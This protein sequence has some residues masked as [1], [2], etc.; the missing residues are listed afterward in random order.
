MLLSQTSVRSIHLTILFLFISFAGFSQT[1]FVD[2]STGNN[3][4]DGSTPALAKLTI[5]AA[6]DLATGGETISV[7]A[8]TYTET[9]IVNKEV[10]LEGPF[11][12][13]AGSD[14]GRGTGE[15]IIDQGAFGNVV[16][17]DG[18]D[19]V[20]IDGFQVGSTMTLQGIV[21]DGNTNITIQNNVII[22]HGVGLNFSNPSGISSGTISIANNL[23]DMIALRILAT[24]NGSVGIIVTN[25][26]GTSEVSIEDNNLVDASIGIG[27]SGLNSS[28]NTASIQGGSITG[29]TT[30]I[31][32]ANIDDLATSAASDIVISGI[33]MSG[34]AIDGTIGGLVVGVYAFATGTGTTSADDLALDIDNLD[35]SGTTNDSTNNAA[36]IIADF[37]SGEPDTGISDDKGITVTISNTNVHDNDNRGIYVRGADAS[38]TIST[39]SIIDNGGNASGSGAGL[40]TFASGAITVENSTIQNPGVQVSGAVSAL[41]SQ[42]NGSIIATSNSINRN[43]NGELGDIQSG[44]TANMSQNWLGTSIESEIEPY[45][46]FAGVDF[47]P[48]VSSGTDSD[49][50]TDGFQP[51]LDTLYVGASGTQTGSSGRVD[52]AIG[53]VDA[54][55]TIIVN[56]GSYDE[57]VTVI[58][59]VSI[60]GANQG[61]AGN[62]TRI[63][64]TIIDPSAPGVGVTIAANNVTIDGLQLGSSSS[65]SNLSTGIL[66][67][68]SSGTAVTNNVVYSNGFGITVST[69]SANSVVVSNNLVSMLNLVDPQ[70][71]N[72]PSIGMFVSTISGTADVNL[73]DNDIS[74]A[75]YGIGGYALTSENTDYINGG[76][77]TGCTQGIAITNA[78]GTGNF[79]R[80]IAS[81]ENVTM[82][83]FVDPGAGLAAPDAQ[84]G[85]YTGTFTD[86]STTTT[87]DSVEL[88]IIGVDI[89]GTGS[90]PSDYAA[91]NVV[92][93][94]GAFPFIDDDGVAVNVTIIDANLHDNLNRG[95]TIRGTNATATISRSTFTNNSNAAVV[96]SRLGYVD[97]NNNFIINPG[98]GSPTAL[99][100][101]TDGTMAGQHNSIDTGNGTIADGQDADDKINLSG[102]YFGTTDQTTI[103]GLIDA[104]NTDFSPWIASG[105]DTNP[106]FA[107]FQPDLSTLHV[108][109]SGDQATGGIIQEGHDLVDTLGTVVVNGNSYTIDTLDVLKDITLSPLVNLTIDELVTDGGNLTVIDNDLTVT[110]ILT[111]NNGA[112]D[113]DEDEGVKTDDPVLT[114]T[115]ATVSGTFS[116]ANHIEGKVASD[117]GAA[118]SLEFPVGDNGNYR[119]VTITPVS[120][121]TFEVAHYSEAAPD[122]T[123]GTNPS[124]SNLIGDVSTAFS[125]AVIQSALTARYWNI[126]RTS[127]T[128]N[129]DVGLQVLDADMEVEPG[130]LSAVKINSSGDWE[131]IARVG[132][133]GSDP[134]IITGQTSDFSPFSITSAFGMAPGNVDVGLQLWLKADEVTGLNDNDPITSWADMSGLGRDATEVTNPPTY[135]NNV[136]D[137]YNFNPVIITDGMDDILSTTSDPLGDSDDFSI[138]IVG[139]NGS[140]VS[141]GMTGEG[142]GWSIR[143]SGSIFTTSPSEQ[144]DITYP[145]VTPPYIQILTFD[146]GASLN[147]YR[148]GVPATH[149]TGVGTGL[150]SS[151]DFINIGIDDNTPSAGSISELIV[152]NRV[153]DPAEQQRLESY[154][155]IK[156]GIPLLSDYLA[157]DGGTIW[158]T[159]TTSGY[160]F[161]NA[162]IGRD[163]FS[164]LDQRKSRTINADSLVTIALGDF[165]NP[166]AF[167]DN[168]AWLIWGNNNGAITF[169][170][171]INNA[172][173]GSS[174]RIERVWKVQETGVVG[175]VELAFNESASTE[176]ISLIVHPSDETFPNDNDRQVYEMVYSTTTDDYRV[177]V[178]LTNGDYF[179]FAEG[180][181]GGIPVVL[182]SEV[183]TDPQLDWSEDEFHNPNL[184][185]AD[186]GSEDEWVELFITENN[187]DLSDWTIELIDGASANGSLEAG[188]VFTFSNYNSL[189]GG[190][191]QATDSG[192]FVIL[193]D[194]TGVL[195]NDQHVILRNQDG[196]VVDQVII[197]NISRGT[198]FDG[199]ADDAENESVTRLFNDS[200][201]NDDASDF[202]K[203][204]A[205]LG[206]T[207][208]VSGLVLINEIVTDPQTDWSENNFDG[209]DGGNT[210]TPVD[211]WI[212]LYIA[213]DD[214]DLT[215]WV[216]D[217]ENGANDIIQQD[218]SAGG[219]FTISNYFSETGGTFTKTDS[220]DYL[221]LGNAAENLIN[222]PE[223]TL[224]DPSGNIIDQVILGGGGSE[225]PDGNANEFDNE[226]IAR[227]PNAADTDTDNID[228]IQ[229]R[230]T[231]GST[232]SPTGTV[233]I[234]EVVTD[235]FQDW[236]S[237]GFDGII[238]A[239]GS[240]NAGTDEWIE[241]YIT[242][243]SINLTNWSIEL[244]DGTDVIGDLTGTG[245]FG[246]TNYISNTSGSSFSGAATGDYLILGDVNGGSQMSND[247]LITLKDSYGT[248]IDEVQLGGGTG[249]A[250]EGANASIAEES[251]ARIP[252][253]LDTDADDV[254]FAKAEATLGAENFVNPLAS[255]GYGL[256]LDGSDEY[257][258]LGAF[259]ELDGVDEFT[260]EA[261]INVDNFTDYDGIVSSFESTSSAIDLL[262]GGGVDATNQGI[263]FRVANGSNTHA[264]TTS[265]P[266]VVD[267]W[268]HVVAVYNGNGS[269]N[270][271][272]IQ[273]YIDGIQMDLAFNVGSPPTTTATVNEDMAI[274][275]YI[276][277]GHYLNGQV[278]DVRIWS[279][280]RT[281][282]EVLENMF[283]TLDGTETGLI[284]Y[285][286]LDQTTGS[287]APDLAGT[288]TGSLTNMENA[289]WV[290]TDWST[291]V[292]NQA[293]LNP[294]TGSD[295]TEAISNEL[296]INESDFLNDDGDFILTGHENSDFT[297]VTTDLPSPAGGTLVT[298]RYDR[299]WHLTKNDESGTTGGNVTFSFDLG[300]AP[301]SDYTYYLLERSTNSGAFSVVPVVGV[302][303]NGNNVV[304]TLDAANLT[305]GNYYTLGRSDAGVGNALDFDGTDDYVVIT[306]DNSLDF[307]ST[308]TLEAW[309][310]L[311][312]TTGSRAIVS[313]YFS[314]TSSETSYR[315]QVLSGLLKL[316]VNNSVA[317]TVSVVDQTVGSIST[318]S[319]H[320]IAGVADGSGNILLYMDGILVGTST[321]DNTVYVGTRDVLIGK[322]RVE[323][324]ASITDGI[325]D[326][327]R[328]WNEA[329]TQEEIIDNMFESL[330]GTES[331]LVA[332]YRM[333]QGIGDGNSSLPDLGPN[334]YNGT[335]TNFDNLSA[336]TASSNY[337][338]SNRVTFSDLA[339]IVNAATDILTDV[340]GELTITS[341]TS[342]YL[343]NTND[344]VIWGNDGGNLSEVQTDLPSGTLV[345]NRIEK[346][347]NIDKYDASSNNGNLTF[348]FDLGS[349]PDPDY[350]YYLLTRTGTSGDFSVVEVIGS[351]PNGSSVEFTVDG[352]E[353]TD[354]NYFTLGRSEA[355][356]GHALDFDGSNDEVDL[357]SHIASFDIDAPATIEFWY[358]PP[359][360]FDRSIDLVSIFS[361]GDNG[362][363]EL[364]IAYGNTT[365]DLTDEVISIFHLDGTATR[366]AYTNASLD[367]NIHHWTLVASGTEYLIYLDGQLVNTTYADPIAGDFGDNIT[368]TEV[369]IGNRASNG[370]L[371]L[372]GVIDELRIWSDV[373]TSQE[374]QDNLY[375]SLDVANESNLVA[376]YKFNDGLAASD[377]S[378]PA[379][380]ILTDY[381]GN[382]FAGDLSGFALTGS[383]SNWIISEVPLADQSVVSALDGPGN[384][385]AFDGSDEYVSIPDNDA[386]DIT[387]ALTLE[388]W[389]S[390]TSSPSN[391]NEGIVS[392]F[393]SAGDERSYSLDITTSDNL[394][395]TLSANGSNE[396]AL[397][398]TSTITT[399]DG[400]TYVAAVFDPSN[401]MSLYIDGILDTE[402]TSGVPA[403]INASAADLWIGL[404]DAIS[405]NN[406]LNAEIDEVRIWATARTRVEIQD[407]MFKQL[408]GN[409]SGLV[410]YYTFDEITGTN[411]PDESPNNNAGTLQNMETADWVSAAAREPEKNIEVNNW[412]TTATWKSRAVPDAITERLDLGQDIIVDGPV[413]VDLL[414]INSG[415]TVTIETGQTLTVNGNFINNGTITGDGTLVIN[416]GTPILYGGTIS[417]LQLAGAD[418]TLMSATTVGDTLDL[419]S[420]S[421]L[422]IDDYNLMV[423]QISG[424]S[425]SA[426]IETKNQSSPSGYIIK[427][428][429]E[430]DGDFTFPVGS[431]GSYT[432][433][434]VKNLGNTGD[435]EARV[436]DNTYA[437]GTSGPIIT[438]EKE[439]N[440]SWEI[441]G[442]AG[443]NV[444]VTL[445]WNGTDE[446][447]NFS[448]AR[449]TAYMSKND[450]NW[451][452]KITPDVGVTGSDPYMIAASGIHTFSVFGTGTE[453]SSLPVTWMAFE[454]FENEEQ[455]VELHWSTASEL[456]NDRFEIE[457]SFDGSAFQVIGEIIGNGTINSQS[458]YEFMDK[459]PFNGINYYRLRQ[460]D[461]D[462]T[463]DYSELVSVFVD[464]QREYNIVLSPN[465]TFDITTLSIDWESD[466]DYAVGIFDMMGRNLGVVHS[467]F[468][469]LNL[470]LT[471]LPKAMYIIKI[472]TGD[473]IVAKKLIKY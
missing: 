289:D 440:K 226:A 295:I 323:D 285:Y 299:S 415:V 44:G 12:G 281:H 471:T 432:P 459:D 74:N 377:N 330:A 421:T 347:W 17:V 304:F 101:Q 65:S 207:S 66:N 141:R 333:N 11:A 410:A 419:S 262:L 355:G 469:E 430:A 201:T 423:N 8:G 242:S 69:I 434:T 342:D 424:F 249:E 442:D 92:D 457:K 209:T 110:S 216:M 267:T 31:L 404:T 113:L 420:N 441:N 319:W 371:F 19:N 257:I 150:R 231:L 18:V 85:V 99:V 316:Q 149:N 336:A 206:N 266:L 223:I 132:E 256:D 176:T 177:T 391:D 235:P 321:Y 58:K 416:G 49:L 143:S 194:P 313:K 4:D 61:T 388:A 435:I 233:V 189:T 272:R 10:R 185:T 180:P 213:T 125:P 45:M 263:Y 260:I 232:N 217:I 151:T 473:R 413:D 32:I 87:A 197:E 116:D 241:L 62:G 456:N 470:N 126:D 25:A 144:Q 369:K 7:A 36:I 335:L 129:A 111:L 2:A 277:G 118:A 348:A 337:V 302:N 452:E 23:I 338:A 139:D 258:D 379:V 436:F 326:E 95:F 252:N 215:N 14:P 130:T 160:N 383:T 75:S 286:N 376:Y 352:A 237:S 464:I 135:Q 346:T 170:E 394:E 345:T 29:S 458:K 303:P 309:I 230:P 24:A 353:V 114:I 361:L 344:M 97:L 186:V 98:S 3:A 298:A 193:G 325:I 268:H 203:T 175:T 380:D 42:Q 461:Y 305:D 400:W 292:S 406:A 408:E 148:S 146:Q 402:L 250:P 463:D 341:T 83:G 234:N 381:S 145:G 168:D 296:D 159:T 96:V 152:Y 167:A 363:E 451:W 76:T 460:V 122:G 109:T 225:A 389:I 466:D 22:T 64:E 349:A 53:L 334:G 140:L 245:A 138:I 123:G 195:S 368:A 162:G 370:D 358:T 219:A 329:R 351:E 236:S 240:V 251:I 183:I 81:I 339:Y 38:A 70:N 340:S 134:Y 198:G 27:V 154:L 82:A 172:H 100:A 57:T 48:W 399:A 253:G 187:L 445:Q 68:G 288:N 395:F 265:A 164:G 13:T 210:P 447:P 1:I 28:T 373:R 455:Q 178:D 307:T 315:L 350:T 50:G 414:N 467:K 331:G 153:V 156:Y 275:Y 453:D 124:L 56:A 401:S 378:T 54:G 199:N 438:T 6:I 163:D 220:G 169:T 328:F 39:S 318:S 425:S 386:L 314:G 104:T 147:G 264:Y 429:A 90:T 21:S 243:D 468:T 173:T 433:L 26:S 212:E 190:L 73:V 55:G 405:A 366:A 20:T 306:D 409:E 158:N 273:I 63:D 119:P 174:N 431:S 37:N 283:T 60:L 88:T 255:P 443:V 437:Q 287:T 396:A 439:V 94:A 269:T 218:L 270:A 137:N 417:N 357:S 84:A 171:S 356:P 312:N 427:S 228:F 310:N 131:E 182:I 112:I 375:R 202:V 106:S 411:L 16:T 278:D 246:T 184:G 446:D 426:Y 165:D 157:A 105:T 472:H 115:G 322:A 247:V 343:Q 79:N 454:A 280:A 317:S 128:G 208:T 360:G 398:S 284:S 102:N 428:L 450:Y 117:I 248:I 52:E 294:S 155:A 91:I 5:Q 259:T 382:D 46:N 372:E 364:L 422:N 136:T 221:V 367:N 229:T 179:T 200:D 448:S 462:G 276:D 465:P 412:N 89:S 407:N 374:I 40:I 59:A 274:G 67:A 222:S 362:T 261:W 196:N 239:G 188:D 71:A 384:A 385:L 77:I 41:L 205:T 293:I 107:G 192:D 279:T 120:A 86:G 78:D 308:F 300:A 254:D 393:L 392:K 211:E 127:G 418:A 227:Y 244:I 47:T 133:S 365:V 282:E 324:V 290:S 93:F 359:S 33:T 397:T 43:G 34:F 191:F 301:N 80:S 15:A 320:H 291:F 103:A 204:R 449:S 51:D 181:V 354:G 161:D 327:V 142:D 121:S 214:L 390:V 387:G 271:E 9:I 72:T 238:G 166:I 311:A 332:Y 297:E 444:T 403:A 30:G 108:G 224:Y 35:I